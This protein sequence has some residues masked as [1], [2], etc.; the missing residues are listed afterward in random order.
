MTWLSGVASCGSG[1]V[2][3]VRS[4]R[5]RPHQVTGSTVILTAD[6]VFDR[7]PEA[8]ELMNL[9]ALCQRCHNL[10]D[11]KDRVPGQRDRVRGPHI[12]LL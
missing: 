3:G 7:R 4:L 9:E 12:S 2:P 11:A 6:H 1:S 8:S 5:R 10:H